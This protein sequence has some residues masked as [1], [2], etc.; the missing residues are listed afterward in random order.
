MSEPMKDN[1]VQD[2][3]LYIYK[4]KEYFVLRCDN[5]ECKD[6]DDGNWYPA[7]AYYPANVEDYPDP[8]C[9]KI[10]LYIRRLEDF[11]A[12]FKPAIP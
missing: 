10:P 7:V 11:Q 8:E 2:G 4:D 6:P 1:E 12:K 9:D 3:K 5:I